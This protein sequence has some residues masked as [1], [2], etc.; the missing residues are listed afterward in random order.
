MSIF[1][2]IQTGQYKFRILL[3][4]I[5]LSVVL[6]LVPAFVFGNEVVDL[7]GTN[8]QISYHALAIRVLTGHGFSFDQD[9]WPATRA[10]EPTAH[11]SFLYTLYLVACYAVFGINPLI[12]RVLQAVIVGILHPYLIFKIG[13]KLVGQS[14]AL[15]AAL[16]TA[17]YAYFFYYAGT[18]MTEPFY[19]T[20]I[21]AVIYLT[22]Q[23]TASGT[24]RKKIW[25]AA[26]LGVALG[27]ITLLRQLFLLF[28]P[29]LMA[30][31]V[32]QEWK[33]K[34]AVLLLEVVLPLFIIG[35]MILPFTLYTLQRFGQPVLL[36]TNAGYALFFGNHPI[37]GTKFISILPPEIG[38]YQSL[39]PTEL[40][41]L[42]EAALDQ[43]L[44]KL[45][46]QYILADPGRYL[47]LSISRIPVYFQFW[48]S[49]DSGL[50]SNLSRVGSFG[51]MLP[52]M[53]YGV[54][55]WIVTEGLRNI[56]SPVWLLLLFGVVYTGIHLM[57][58]AL[59]RYRLP[60]D[61][62]LLLFAGYA[63][64]NLYNLIKKQKR[65]ALH[66]VES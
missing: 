5:A 46:I 7:P 13:E 40:F 32:F 52:F 20:A 10:G 66:S 28:I 33:Q 37:Y 60:V 12:A 42:S 36:N 64:M 23:M 11:W 62:V 65:A 58:W 19:I 45:A 53:L 30:W 18:L 31:I 55:R 35:L 34:R 63:I 47:L 56:T 41:P 43:A 15:V 38:S 25:L 57:T 39:I 6:R 49:A 4:I 1:S 17:G 24:G 8:D 22:M 51:V 29:F 48:P 26:G 54:I 27:I 14:A 61:A 3:A 21:L 59:I 2:R 44:L 16:L 9:W 50:I